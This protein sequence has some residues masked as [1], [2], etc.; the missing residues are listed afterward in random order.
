MG[1][2]DLKVD[3]IPQI[4]NIQDQLDITGKVMNQYVDT[5]TVSFS[6]T[7]SSFPVDRYTLQTFKAWNQSFL[8]RAYRKYQVLDYGTNTYT[9]EA[10]ARKVPVAK[11][12]VTIVLPSPW[13]VAASTVPAKFESQTLSWAEALSTLPQNPSSFWTP[14]QLS[15]S[16]MSYSRL[17]AFQL[18]KSQ[19]VMTLS[20]QNYETYLKASVTWYYWDH[21]VDLWEGKW[22]VV[23]VLSLKGE[24]YSYERH[25]ID[26]KYGWYGVLLLES[27]NGI[28][29][30][31]FKAKS[32]K[33]KEMK[34]SEVEKGDQWFWELYGK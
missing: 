11:V 14:I 33:L 18:I 20:C 7:T 25:Y 6:N 26:R 19:D 30:T 21:C 2:K 10:S 34:F 32:D 13:E 12:V 23:N 29:P 9:I 22:F 24:V 4:A 8:Y 28:R 31:D 1:E 5:I 17:K 15:Q 27:G 16:M 3:D